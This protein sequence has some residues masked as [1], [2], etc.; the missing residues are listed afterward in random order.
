MVIAACN[1][2]TIAVPSAAVNPTTVNITATTTLADVQAAI[3][4]IV[5]TNGNPVAFAQ[6]DNN[7]CLVIKAR[8]LTDT[9]TLAQTGG[10][11]LANLGI[12]AGQ[13]GPAL[14]P[15]A[16]GGAATPQL[17][18]MTDT[19]NTEGW[20]Q[21]S[22]RTPDGATIT[23]GN[24]NFGGD[25]RLNGTLDVNGRTLVALDNIDWL[26]GSTQQDINFNIAGFTQFAGEYN[27][28]SSNQNGAALGLR[29][30]LSVSEDGVVTAQFSNGQ[31]QAIYQI[32]IATFAN[33]NGLSEATGNVFRQSTESGDFN[34]REAGKGSAGR[35]QGGSL[36]ASN[37]DLA[38]E[39]SKMIVT[40][41][42]YSA[43]TKVLQT[44]DQMTQELLQLR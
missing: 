42:A 33:P 12:P 32:P 41:R 36:E 1:C 30:G 16:G 27:V 39:F 5:D 21:V 3:N 40:Q 19:P 9:V 28:I 44:A 37:V 43:D 15:P 7:N 23:S 6:L 17:T 2:F 4:G 38:D 25:G 34:L 31:S 26:N 24:I 18:T 8:N 22:F 10:T 11:P 13:I 29:T 35:V 14:N 20:W